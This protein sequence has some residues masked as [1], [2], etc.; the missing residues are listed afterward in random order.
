[1]RW[2][3]NIDIGSILG[4]YRV[5][6]G[7][8]VGGGEGD[9]CGVQA[10]WV[11]GQCWVNI[12]GRGR[13]RRWVVDIA[14]SISGGFQMDKFGGGTS[15]TSPHCPGGLTLTLTLTLTLI[16]E[17]RHPIAQEVGHDHRVLLSVH[18]L[19]ASHTVDHTLMPLTHP[20]QWITCSCR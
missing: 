17:E 5:N 6:I 19:H 11:S 2:A 10:I 3:D 12:V 7:S 15:R 8:M 18:R 16:G 4:Q 20:T 13:R 1:M 14:R 9:L